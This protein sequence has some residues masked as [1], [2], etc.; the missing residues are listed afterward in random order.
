MNE[1]HHSRPTEP[2]LE[3]VQIVTKIEA[4]TKVFRRA[5]YNVM[6]EHDYTNKASLYMLLTLLLPLSLILLCMVGLTFL[7]VRYFANCCSAHYDQEYPMRGFPS[8]VGATLLGC[9]GYFAM[10]ISVLLFA[11]VA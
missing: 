6:K 5:V 4:E 9:G 11:M 10:L 1:L 3:T 8:R 7:L 2:D